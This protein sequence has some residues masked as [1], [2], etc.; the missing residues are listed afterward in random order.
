MITIKSN[1]APFLVKWSMKDKES[2]TLQQI[3][4]NADEYKG[5]STSFP[6]PMLVV[7]NPETLENYCFQ[8]KAK[9]VIGFTEKVIPGKNNSVIIK[10]TFFIFFNSLNNHH[11]NSTLL[12]SLDSGD[13]RSVLVRCASIFEHFSFYYD[14]LDLIWCVASIG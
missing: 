14:Y 4:V 13:L 3:N 9:N 7:K 8:I 11:S 1:P 5:T 12:R 6:H 10:N 2:E